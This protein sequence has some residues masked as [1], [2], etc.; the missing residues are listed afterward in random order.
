MLKTQHNAWVHLAI[1]ILV[2]GA[3]MWFG[4]TAADWRWL[5]VAIA[6][7]WVAETTNTAFEFLCDAVVPDFHISVEKAKDVA[8]AAVLICAAAS[9]IIGV[10]VFLPYF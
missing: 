4:I 1:S 9:A 2:I 5:V 6:L 10:M 7:V 8:A 3:G